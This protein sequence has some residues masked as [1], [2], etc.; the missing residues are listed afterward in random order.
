MLEKKS[1]VLLVGLGFEKGFSHEGYIFSKDNLMK[2]LLT[3]NKM[4]CDC[5]A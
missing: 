4:K 2:M 3:I 1:G 5:K